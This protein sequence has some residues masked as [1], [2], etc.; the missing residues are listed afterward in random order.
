MRITTLNEKI[1]KLA[2]EK[3]EVE[4]ERKELHA[5]LNDKMKQINEI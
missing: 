4:K 3:G 1:N 5:T 2:G